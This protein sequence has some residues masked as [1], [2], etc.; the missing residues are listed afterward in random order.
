MRRPLIFVLLAVLVLLGCR[1]PV[2]TTSTKQQAIDKFARII[3]A[4]IPAG[5]TNVHG[6]IVS[7][8]TTVIDV[9]F[10]C[11]ESDLQQFLNSCD[12]LAGGLTD[13]HRSVV[14]TMVSESWWTPDSF[15]E[16]R[17]TELAWNTNGDAVSLNLM[18]GRSSNSEL[19]TVF[20]AITLENDSRNP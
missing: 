13:G 2:Q 14:D 11:S 1:Q 5:A 12:K 9:R 20:G 19:V 7:V 17:G 8:F 4:K 3:G 6:R 10:S 18:A 15:T 16:V